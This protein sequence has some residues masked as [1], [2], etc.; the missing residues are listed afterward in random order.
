MIKELWQFLME[1]KAWWLLPI[2]IVLIFIAIL[3]LVAG[4]GNPAAPFVYTLF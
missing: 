3:F 1:R 2:L 4:P